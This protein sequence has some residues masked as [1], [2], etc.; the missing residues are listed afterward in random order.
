MTA[1]K[2]YGL[3]VD[4]HFWTDDVKKIG[5]ILPRKELLDPK[6]ALWL[7]LT[8]VEEML[9]PSIR[10]GLSLLALA[11]QA[12]R[13]TGLPI[14]I[15]QTS[16]DPISPETLTTPLKAAEVLSHK[17]TVPGAKLVAMVHQPFQPIVPEYRFDIYGHEQ[18]GQ[19]F[20]VGPRQTDWKGAMFG[21]HGG[22]ITI[23]AVGPKGRLPEKS[24]L[25]YPMKGMKLVLG[26]EEY[27]AWAVQNP[28]NQ[29]TSYYIKVDGCP[30]SIIFGPL[31]EKD[32]AD[33]Y[34]MKLK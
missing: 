23:H 18:I 5:W 3:T 1:M 22:E 19:W 29:D 16:G 8:S 24:V 4:G 26:K 11:V 21:V 20:E 2:P 17:G 14:T 30:D 28:L 12:N 15:L 33:V 34:M 25:H 9:K 27:V 10:Y 31:A 32:E 6:T 13:E 7:I